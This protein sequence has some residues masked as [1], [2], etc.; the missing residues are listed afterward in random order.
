LLELLLKSTYDRTYD[1]KEA[2]PLIASGSL[3]DKRRDLIGS[4]ISPLNTITPSSLKKS[5]INFKKSVIARSGTA[6]QPRTNG[7]H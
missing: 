5:E 3:A 1:P 7:A 2:E 6:S 4:T